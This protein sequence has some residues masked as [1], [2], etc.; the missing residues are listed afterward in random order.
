[1]CECDALL[2]P[3]KNDA[4]VKNNLGVK[5]SFS[6]SDAFLNYISF[7]RAIIYLSKLITSMR[8]LLFHIFNFAPCVPY[9]T[10]IYVSV[11]ASDCQCF[12]KCFGSTPNYMSAVNTT[13]QKFVTASFYFFQSNCPQVFQVQCIKGCNWWDKISCD[14]LNQL[15]HPF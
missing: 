6:Y 9:P 13:C 3:M 11:T 4:R 14:I 10:V 7:F 8:R 12:L 15:E 2:F 5:Y 1:M